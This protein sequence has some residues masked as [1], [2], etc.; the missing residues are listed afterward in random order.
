MLNEKMINTILLSP[1]VPYDLL[2]L[3]PGKIRFVFMHIPPFEDPDELPP[4]SGYRPYIKSWGKI[5]DRGNPDVV[6][7]GHTHQPK[8]VLPRESGYS[9]PLIIGGGSSYKKNQFALVRVR[10]GETQIESDLILEDG[11][12]IGRYHMNRE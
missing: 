10:A 1:T 8:I 2:F 12:I 5:L 7:A 4:Q 6:F 3:I 11:S 9:F